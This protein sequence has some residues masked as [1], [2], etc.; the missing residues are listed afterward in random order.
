MFG[1]PGA[2]SPGPMPP[3]G[4]T[5]PAMAPAP[6]AGAAAQGMAGVEA[7]LKMLQQAL[8]GL[9][10]GS[11]LHKAVLKSVADIAKSMEPG[12]ADPAAQMQQLIAAAR[13]AQG[14]PPPPQAGAMQSMFP[15]AGGPSP[16][17]H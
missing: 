8:P 12:Q 9:P 4:G 17:A 16:M 10:M 6:M 1:A 11:D 14:A 3:Q 2:P 13:A 5:G 7:A 15:S